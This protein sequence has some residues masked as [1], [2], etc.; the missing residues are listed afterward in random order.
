VCFRYAPRTVAPERLDA[1]NAELGEKLV[2]DGRVFC[3]TT[4]YR[5]MTA[6]RPAIVN[7]RT[8]E[9]DVMLLLRVLRELGEQL[10]RG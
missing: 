1:L 7:W 2:D 9:G 8:T 5:C 4:R 6:F 10:L 3:G